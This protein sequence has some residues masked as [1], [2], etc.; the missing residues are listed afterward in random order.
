MFTGDSIK[1]E[2]E[3]IILGLRESLQKRLRFIT[4]QSLSAIE[5][6]AQTSSAKEEP[7]DA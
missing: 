6:S 2:L 4:H 1:A 5:K 7:Q 3:P